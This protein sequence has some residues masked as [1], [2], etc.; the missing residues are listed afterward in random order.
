M[1]M[2]IPLSII[3]QAALPRSDTRQKVSFLFIFRLSDEFR[4]LRRFQSV[5]FAIR[6]RPFAFVSF[7]TD[8][9]I[10]FSRH[11]SRH[12][13]RNRLI[14]IFVSDNRRFRV[15]MTHFSSHHFASAHRRTVCRFFNGFFRRLFR[16]FSFRSVHFRLSISHTVRTTGNLRFP[17]LS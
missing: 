2:R 16:S 14:P 15:P 3:K 7:S 8:R 13:R 4:E 9:F 6:N 11:F 12:H 10:D 17:T 5:S 1:W